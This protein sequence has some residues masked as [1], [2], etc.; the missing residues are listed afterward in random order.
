M[1]EWNLY[2]ERRKAQ[3]FSPLFPPTMDTK[4]GSS[5]RKRS[6]AAVSDAEN[7]AKSKRSSAKKN[8]GK[9]RA[10]NTDLS[11][12]PGPSSISRAKPQ[13]R[14]LQ[15][16]KVA[17]T[18]EV[19]NSNKPLSTAVDSGAPISS[20]DID[21]S[22]YQSPELRTSPCAGDR[23]MIGA[24]ETATESLE[25]QISELKAQLRS[26]EESLQAKDRIVTSQHAVF[27]ELQ[28]ACAC[29]ICLE[30]VW[31]PCVL[32]PCGHIFCIR[33][34][35][36]WFTKPLDSEAA[37]PQ[38]FSESHRQDYLRSR[39]LKRKKICP[40][41]RTELAC[42]PVEI[43]L[44]RDILDKV[45][46]AT[47]LAPANGTD[48]A[49]A[50][51]IPQIEKGD[52]LPAASKIWLDVFSSHGPR[53]IIFDEVDRVPRCGACACEIFDGACTN[54]SCGIEYD[55][56]A[57]LAA[58]MEDWSSEGDGYSSDVLNTLRDIITGPHEE[59]PG[60]FDPTGSSD[61][62][63][64]DADS[65]GSFIED[66]ARTFSDASADDDFLPGPRR[67]HN[68]A[69][70]EITDDSQEDDNEHGDDDDDSSVEEVSASNS[71]RRRLHRP[72]FLDDEAEDDDEHDDEDDDDDFDDHDD[73]D[74]SGLIDDE[75]AVDVD[76][77]PTSASATRFKTD[78]STNT[79]TADAVRT[80]PRRV[81]HDSDD[82]D[83]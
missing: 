4:A 49:S 14:P 53:R 64:C 80:R 31:R 8:G 63:D 48:A 74:L 66:D 35:Q 58:D 51:E 7:G 79:T 20:E 75:D 11:N 18:T 10:A 3:L 47:T 25:D 57:R 28:S 22:E 55:S 56:D 78:N 30:L 2:V 45:Q 32:A 61:L 9:R 12:E 81:I 50:A 33:C 73:D 59:R 37:P 41:C 69:P 71:G 38:H 23:R 67:V 16:E 24:V 40:S 72:T 17:R 34:L 27:E 1:T 29:Q 6:S 5:S 26:A 52:D 70:I 76:T 43:W 54:P 39:T 60:I 68:S 46:T 15:T 82:D 21:S 44:V 77:R 65:M 36:S 19:A 13:T 42:P 62:D 83:T